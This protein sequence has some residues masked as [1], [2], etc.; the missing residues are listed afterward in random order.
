MRHNVDVLSLLRSKGAPESCFVISDSSEIDRTEQ[1]LA[2]AL[3]K[4]RE[5]GWGTIISCIPGQLGFFYGEEGGIQLIL[6]KNY[7]NKRLVGTRNLSASQ[8][9]PAPHKRSVKFLKL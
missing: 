9:E 4:M 5:Y 1:V 8:S 7:D 6:E 3:Q 2:T